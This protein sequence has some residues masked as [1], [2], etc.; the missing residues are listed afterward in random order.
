M[1]WYS[2]GDQ[3]GITQKVPHSR[4]LKTHQYVIQ[5]R[6]GLSPAGACFRKNRHL[7]QDKGYR[8]KKNLDRI[9]QL[10]TPASG[11]T[12]V[13]CKIAKLGALGNNIEQ[14]LE[15]RGILSV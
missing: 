4:R 1:G 7:D 10:L 12:N 13:P 11:F 3:G 5:R 6:S 2:P 14:P 15:I 9:L 8:E